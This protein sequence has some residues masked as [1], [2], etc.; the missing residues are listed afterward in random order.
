ME[1]HTWAENWLRFPP[2]EGCLIKIKEKGRTGLCAE[3]FS[4]AFSLILQ[5]WNC[6][7]CGRYF[8]DQF[9]KLD[10][11]SHRPQLQWKLEDGKDDK[12]QK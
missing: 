1:K 2:E 12:D 7:L 10:S 3:L 6:L 11:L 4:K 5:P 8:C 9:T